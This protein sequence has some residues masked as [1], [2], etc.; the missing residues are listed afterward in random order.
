MAKGV[1]RCI[2]CHHEIVDG[3]GSSS[4]KVLYTLTHCSQ[5]C[6]GCGRDY[7]DGDD[8]EEAWDDRDSDIFPPFFGHFNSHFDDDGT[9][10]FEDDGLD[11]Y[12]SDFIDDGTIDEPEESLL[13]VLTHGR[14]TRGTNRR[15]HHTATHSEISHSRSESSSGIAEVIELSSEDEDDLPPRQVRPR[16][17]RIQAYSISDDSGSESRDSDL[18]IEVAHRER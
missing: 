16:R 1:Y 4:L 12:E 15:P 3:V 7:A 13:R 5:F 17:G 11:T 14:R 8:D 6:S 18:L 2:T 10:F 9:M